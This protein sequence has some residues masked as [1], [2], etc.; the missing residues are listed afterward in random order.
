MSGRTARKKSSGKKVTH[1][2]LARL[3]VNDSGEDVFPSKAAKDEA[4]AKD[5]A[6]KRRKRKARRQ[7]RPDRPS[8][9][10]R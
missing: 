1:A 8:L 10:T 9:S 7:P 4:V 5:R 6:A 2:E 3:G